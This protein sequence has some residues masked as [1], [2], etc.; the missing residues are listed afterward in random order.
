MD[1]LHLTKASLLLVIQL[2]MPPLIAAI[3]SGVMISLIQT[4][5]SVQDQTLPFTV[6]LLAVAAILLSTGGW[7][8]SNVVDLAGLV[9]SG[10]ADI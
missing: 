9:F 1:F 7:M 8:M 6:K 3:I 5:F 2:S 4:L 10:V